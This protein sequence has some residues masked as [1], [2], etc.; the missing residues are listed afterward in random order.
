VEAAE[1]LVARLLEYKRFRAASEWMHERFAMEQGY[2]YRAAPLPPELRRVTLEAAAQAYDPS[3]LTEAL[4]GLLRV[5]PPVDT[6]HMTRVTVSLERRLA[7][8]RDLLRSR[9]SFSFDDA[10]GDSDRMTQAV[11]LFALLEL[12]KSGELVWRQRE[13]FGPI[14]IMS[15]PEP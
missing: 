8:L 4:A 3:R 7:H 15:R 1:E 14:E 10:V 5:P 2:R 9:T 12:Y 13:N 6:S 11:T